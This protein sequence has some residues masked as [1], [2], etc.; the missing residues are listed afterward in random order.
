MA[1]SPNGQTVATE[2]TVDIEEIKRLTL[3]ARADVTQ[4]ELEEVVERAE[5]IV[6]TLP[7][8]IREAALMGDISVDPLV[9]ESALDHRTSELVALWCTRQGLTVC[10]LPV[11]DEDAPHS[12]PLHMVLHVCWPIKGPFSV[13]GG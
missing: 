3:E 6:A 4:E 8:R 1:K 2:P 7:Q 12:P 11:G 9:I 13:S 5:R 10:Y